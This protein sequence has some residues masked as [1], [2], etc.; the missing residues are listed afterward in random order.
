MDYRGEIDAPSFSL[1][2]QRQTSVC[3]E[4]GSIASRLF[5]TPLC[6][7]HEAELRGDAAH[8]PRVPS[9]VPN[10]TPLRGLQRAIQEPVTFGPQRPASKVSAHA[11]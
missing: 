1:G 9:R 4:Y 10:C 6:L 2:R 5:C 3:H 11:S 7:E 8:Q